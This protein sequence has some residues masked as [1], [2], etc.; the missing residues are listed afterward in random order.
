[1][2]SNRTHAA[3]LGRRM[4]SACF[5]NVSLVEMETGWHELPRRSPR[6]QRESRSVCRFADVPFGFSAV[7]DLDRGARESRAAPGAGRD[8]RCDALRIATTGVAHESSTGFIAPATRGRSSRRRA[9]ACRRRTRDLDFAWCHERARTACFE[10]RSVQSSRVHPSSA[11]LAVPPRRTE[12]PR[13]RRTLAPLRSALEAR[14]ASVRRG[15]G[16]SAWPEAGA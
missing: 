11:A 16:P 15:F 9:R 6:N 5:G 3:T 2:W 7:L 14:R 10:T 12:K 4:L 1:M 8:A 13:A